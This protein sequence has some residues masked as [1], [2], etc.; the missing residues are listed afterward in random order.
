MACSI[1]N[2]DVLVGFEGNTSETYSFSDTEVEDIRV[3]KNEVIDL[4]ESVFQTILFEVPLRV[5]KE[6]LSEYPK[7]D[8]WEV[9]KESDY[10][11]Q[12]KPID[13]RLAKL[14]E[15]KTED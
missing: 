4:S 9:L 5:V 10:Q 14:L 1:S 13:P 7:G 2:E 6:G 15:F 8:G 12:E 11:N 3:V